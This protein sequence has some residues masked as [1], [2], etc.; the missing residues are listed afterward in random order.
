MAVGVATNTASNP[1]CY[2]RRTTMRNN[3]SHTIMGGSC[4]YTAPQ[5]ARVRDQA[6][7]DECGLNL[8]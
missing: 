3:Q 7:K 8:P 1:P 6:Y 2:H 4:D 5:R